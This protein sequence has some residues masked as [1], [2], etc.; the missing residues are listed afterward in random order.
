MIAIP[1]VVVCLANVRPFMYGLPWPI[2]TGITLVLFI[3]LLG[4]L[5]TQV[6]V[7][8]LSSLALFGE[9]GR[10]RHHHAFIVAF[11]VSWLIVFGAVLELIAL[12]VTAYPF[13]RRGPF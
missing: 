2:G 11:M 5:V 10:A 12:L 4:G 1:Q 13:V 3:C 7:L 6:H 8:R 9:P